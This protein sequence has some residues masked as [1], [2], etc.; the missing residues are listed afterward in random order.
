MKVLLLLL[1]VL[2]WGCA[3]LPAAG[4]AASRSAT[5]SALPSSTSDGE[6]PS[7]TPEPVI[8]ELTPEETIRIVTAVQEAELVESVASPDATWLAEVYAYDCVEVTPGQEYAYQE[9]RLVKTGEVGADMAASQLI[10]CGGLGAY[11]LASRFWSADS[12]FFYYTDAA[13]GVPDGCGFWTPPF[14]RLDTVDLQAERLGEG[15]LSPDGMLLAAWQQDRLGLWRVDGEAIARIE[16]PSSRRTPGPL[17]WRPDSSAV[18]FVVTEGSCP[19]G[20]SDV[21]RV[22][23]VDMQPV[24][25]L[26]SQDPGFTEVVWDAPNRLALTDED[27]GQWR[28][29]LTTGD[30]RRFG[31]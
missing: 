5:E 25:V 11:G 21:G 26:T 3:P 16:I 31:P 29:N 7:F 2:A 4:P 22:D 30:L 18:A 15:S 17:A 12:R 10:A 8:R 27:G 19:L 14:W 24:V 23:M 1:L 6:L 20:E 13:A 9:L 28:Y